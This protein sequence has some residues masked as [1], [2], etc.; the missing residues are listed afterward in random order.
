VPQDQSIYGTL[1]KV[2]GHWRRYS[3]PQLR[4]R[5]EA[6]GF[7]VEH[8]LEFN[9]VARPGWILNGRILKRRHFGRLQLWVFDRLVWLWRK[10]DGALPWRAVSLIAVG[11]KR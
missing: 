7:E 5:L 6:A 3:E 2:L 8:V 4:E 11:R 1:D 10:I 9:R